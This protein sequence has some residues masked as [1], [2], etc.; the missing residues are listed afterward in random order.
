MAD[1]SQFKEVYNWWYFLGALV[2]LLAFPLLPTICGWFAFY[3][4][5]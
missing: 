3:I 1:D 4:G 5:K 2:A